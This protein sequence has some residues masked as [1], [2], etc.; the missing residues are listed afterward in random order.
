MAGEIEEEK[1]EEREREKSRVQ[2]RDAGEEGSL[3]CC[4]R[5]GPGWLGVAPCLI[6]GHNREFSIT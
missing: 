4:G 6:G 2:E 3:I 5:V 1:I